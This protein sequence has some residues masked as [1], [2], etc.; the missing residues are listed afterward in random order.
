M[1]TEFVIVPAGKHSSV[2][3]EQSCFGFLTYGGWKFCWLVSPAQVHGLPKAIGEFDT[4]R[5][6]CHVRFN[7]L[8]SFR[9][10]LQIQVVGEQ[11]KYFLAFFIVLVL[12]HVLLLLLRLPCHANIRQNAYVLLI[13][14]DAI[15]FSPHPR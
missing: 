12:F 13:G 7:V 5:T 3:F 11:G 2:G 4:R 15:W 14:L 8:A 6:T 9:R 1:L 10:Q